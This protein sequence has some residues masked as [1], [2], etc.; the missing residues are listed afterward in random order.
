[1]TD[2]KIKLKENLET[3]KGIYYKEVVNFNKLLE[4]NEAEYLGLKAFFKNEQNEKILFYIEIIS[5]INNLC[6]SQI[7]N[8]TNVLKK[9]N[10][11]KEDINIRRDLKLFEQ[12][13][14]FS[15]N[16][17]KKRFIEEQFLNYEF[18][19]K[20]GSKSRKDSKSNDGEDLDK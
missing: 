13:F 5:L 9:M 12:D 7:E 3:K 20:S 10:K 1:M 2:K 6:K 15:N 19:K 17:T 18:R 8:M 4:A 14:N 11:Y 16:A